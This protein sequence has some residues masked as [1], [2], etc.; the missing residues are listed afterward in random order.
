MNHPFGMKYMNY[1]DILCRKDRHYE[2]LMSGVPFRSVQSEDPLPP[3][4]SPAHLK[5]LH[6]LAELRYAC[7]DRLSLYRG[8]NR[9]SVERH[10]ENLRSK[11]LVAWFRWID[12][13]NILDGT[14]T[15][16]SKCVYCL[17]S[18][19]VARLLLDRAIEDDRHLIIRSWRGRPR[20]HGVLSHQ[21]GIVD[22]IIGLRL[23]ERRSLKNEILWTLPDFVLDRVDGKSRCAT[24]E[25]IGKS[26]VRPDMVACLRSKTT[27]ERYVLYVEYE[28]TK[29]Q[30]N[31]VGDKFR[32]YS[33]L[34]RARKRRF[35]SGKPVLLY[36]L[37]PCRHDEDT[38][39]RKKLVRKW[40]SEHAIAPAFRTASLSDVV[41]DAFGPVWVKA[42]GEPWSIE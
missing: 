24:I 2:R 22:I 32:N 4:V 35:D 36:V 39:D 16:P 33:R 5:T 21:I 26:E 14:H 12:T 8:L 7:A 15:M 34:F 9:R 18:L 19:G 37:T 20:L 41:S 28:R 3:N 11:R 38:D 27:G 6:A 42:T 40:A 30:R 1:Y 25:P 29:K 31:I 23:A 10:L 17:T 13:S